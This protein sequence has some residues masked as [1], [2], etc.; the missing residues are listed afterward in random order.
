V[1]LAEAREPSHRDLRAKPAGTAVTIRA[2]SWR[3]RKFRL[4]ACATS[5]G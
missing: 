4:T 1:R 2:M 3:E 5:G